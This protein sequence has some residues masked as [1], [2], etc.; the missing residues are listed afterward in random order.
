MIFIFIVQEKAERKMNCNGWRKKWREK[1]IHMSATCRL[2]LFTC[3]CTWYWTMHQITKKKVLFCCCCCRY[4]LSLT[5]C[6]C[7]IPKDGKMKTWSTTL[8]E[9]FVKHA[10]HA[11]FYKV[12]KCFMDF[13]LPFY[14]FS[15]FVVEVANIS[16]TK[17]HT[18]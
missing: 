8:N 12:L 4:F 5:A 14:S 6:H 2:C 9:I 17:T 15:F 13:S 18:L 10:S 3:C 11:N 7:N 1:T 16:H